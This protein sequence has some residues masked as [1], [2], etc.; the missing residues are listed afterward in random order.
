MLKRFVTLCVFRGA[1]DVAAMREERGEMRRSQTGG[2]FDE[3][4]I[5]VRVE[6]HHSTKMS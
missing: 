2:G 6:V 4:R 1:F 5:F 3:A